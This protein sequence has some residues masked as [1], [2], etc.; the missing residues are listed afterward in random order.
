MTRYVLQRLVAAAGVIVLVMVLLSVAV[1][2]I[3]GDPVRIILGG[4]ATPELSAQV[5]KQMH[6]DE[7][8][9]NQVAGYVWRALHGNLGT[10]FLTQRP[11]RELIGAAL[12]HTIVLGLASMLFAVAL[13]IPLGVSSAIRAGG[14][15]DRVLRLLSIATITA[16]SYVVGLLLLLLVTVRL[17]LL[18]GTGNGETGHPLD[19]LEHLILPAV[20]LGLAWVGYLARLVR[21]S[22]LEVLGADYVRTA[23][24]YGLRG[25]TVVWQYA[26]RNALI[27]TIAVLGVGTGSLLAG[28]VFIENIFARVGIGSQLVNAIE[29]RNYPLVQGCILVTAL[30]FV[31][32]NLVADVSYRA[33]DP[34]IRTGGSR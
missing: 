31:G 24:A 6:L 26:L 4:R 18:P 14:I 3:P 27:P 2:L 1:H 33:L 17:Q 28:A 9:L 25:R 21:A 20:A 29:Q 19:Y 30:L 22:M 8:L 34:R 5:R 32:A 7:P 16:P 12:P 11:V 13:G 23:R 15:G 10:D